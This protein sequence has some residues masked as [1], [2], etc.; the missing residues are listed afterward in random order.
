[1][2]RD[3]CG[4]VYHRDWTAARNIFHDVLDIVADHL[5]RRERITSER[6][7]FERVKQGWERALRIHKEHAEDEEGANDAGTAGDG[8]S[9]GDGHSAWARRAR[10]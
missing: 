7:R 9:G 2:W 1:M 5:G 8:G 6:G 3:T 10:P 4:K